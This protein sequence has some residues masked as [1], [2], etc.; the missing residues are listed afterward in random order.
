M[1]KTPLI[2]R[3]GYRFTG[4]NADRDQHIYG[5]YRLEA[6]ITGLAHACDLTPARIRQIIAEGKRGERR[7]PSA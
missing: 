1:A 5:L 4:R 7:P 3:R 6:N 2:L